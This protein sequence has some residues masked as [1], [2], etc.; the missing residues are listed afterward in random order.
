MKNNIKPAILFG[1]KL[2]LGIVFVYSSFHKIED[3][4][5]FAKIIYGYDLFPKASINLIAIC[6]PFIELTAG[7]FLIF[8]LFPRSAMI[9]INCMLA[10]FIVLIAYNLARG[11]QFDCGCFSSMQ[12]KNQT[13]L[14]IVS[15]VRDIVLLGAGVFYLRNTPPLP[16]KS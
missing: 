2:L 10:L 1:I 5:G 6:V 8:G 12:T 15:L 16:S 14:N 9:V 7:F 3:P 11:H 13:L 4:A